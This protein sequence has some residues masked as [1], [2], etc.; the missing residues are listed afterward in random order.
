[1]RYNDL[2]VFQPYDVRVGV[3]R[4]SDFHFKSGTFLYVEIFQF[5]HKHWFYLMFHSWKRKVMILSRAELPVYNPGD[6]VISFLIFRA[7][8]FHS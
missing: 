8:T 6:K 3:T 7:N 1:M 4:S 5:F 2:T